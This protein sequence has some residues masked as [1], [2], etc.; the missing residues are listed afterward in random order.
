MNPPIGTITP[1]RRVAGLLL[2]AGGGRRLGGRAKALLSAGGRPLVE[3][4]AEALRAAGCDPVHVVL[5]ADLEE[6]YART[7]LD[8][9]RVVAHR[10]WA[11]GMGSS[12]RAG[13]D[14]LAGTDA[15]A[16]VVLLVDQPGIGARAVARLVTHCGRDGTELA[17]AAYG[18]ERGHPV[19]LGRRHWAGVADSARGD[20]GARAYLRE[21]TGELTL[22]ECGDV[23]DPADIDTPADLRLL[24]RDYG[25]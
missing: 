7:R 12:L 5:G 6:V 21:H 15:A 20:R 13:L 11:Q 8:G 1:A 23:A 3:R 9:C 2:A 10:D 22:V 4:A 17:A 14:S 16:V 19:L 18:G 25:G 24:D